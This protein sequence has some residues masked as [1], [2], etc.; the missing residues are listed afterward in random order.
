MES[1]LQVRIVTGEMY[2]F[3]CDERELWSTSLV[4]HSIDTGEVK[5]IYDILAHGD[6]FNAAVKALCRV[7][8]R[9]RGPGWSGIL[10]SKS[11][12]E[13]RYCVNRRELLAV[14]LALC[15]LGEVVYQVQ[16]PRQGRRVALHCDHLATCKGYVVPWGPGV[17]EYVSGSS[18]GPAVRILPGFPELGPKLGSPYG[19]VFR[20]VLCSL[21]H[22]RIMLCFPLVRVGVVPPVAEERGSLPICSVRRGCGLQKLKIKYSQLQQ[23]HL[24]R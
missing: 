21:R 22:C 16:L 8:E 4:Q 18:A 17:E 20:V 15:H 24:V 7:L 19:G 3:Y 12:A 5:P 2:R 6:S 10:T 14:V 13:W 23:S 1:T 11:K 9:I